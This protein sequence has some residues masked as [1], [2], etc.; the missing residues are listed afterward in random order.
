MLNKIF[1]EQDVIEQ[2]EW[3]LSINALWALRFIFIVEH[4]QN[5][6]LNALN[7]LVIVR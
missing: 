6:G 1:S 3:F 4:P 5:Q 7:W 2:S